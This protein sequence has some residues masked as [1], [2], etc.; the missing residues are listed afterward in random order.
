MPFANYPSDGRALMDATRKFS[1]GCLRAMREFRHT[2][3]WRGSHAEK[4]EKYRALHNALCE[5]YGLR[6]NLAFAWQGGDRGD[7]SY[8][9]YTKTITL[10]GR[11]SVVTYL[12]EFA[13]ARFGAD[14][15][16]AV[17]WSLSLFA[18]EIGRAHV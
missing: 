12:H 11:P 9:P 6:V 1:P 18:R 5:A 10:R 17:A 3:P 8:T 15:H 4:M 13:H 14:E 2:K 16:V 7:S